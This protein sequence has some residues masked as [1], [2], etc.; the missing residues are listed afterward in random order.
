MKKKTLLIFL[1]CYFAYTAI[2]IARVNLSMAAPELREIQILTEA[3][4]GVLG[5]VFSII[6]SVMQ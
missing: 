5:S 4:Y 2:Y 6:Y 1:I 3:Q